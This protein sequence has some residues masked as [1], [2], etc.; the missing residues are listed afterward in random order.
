MIKFKE[1]VISLESTK[2]LVFCRKMTMT[3]QRVGIRTLDFPD[4]QFTVF[5]V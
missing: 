5:E 1:D 4:F 3:N 2:L